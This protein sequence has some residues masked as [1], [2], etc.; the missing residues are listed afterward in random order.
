MDKQLVM[1]AEMMRTYNSLS[2]KEEYIYIIK[3]VV[4]N[5][6]SQKVLPKVKHMEKIQRKWRDRDHINNSL[7]DIFSL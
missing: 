5:F 2:D 4:P 6:F 1:Y 3:G 7:K